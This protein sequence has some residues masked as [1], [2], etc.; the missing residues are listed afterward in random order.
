MIL[1]VGSFSF[2]TTEPVSYKEFFRPQYE[3]LFTDVHLVTDRMTADRRGFGSFCDAWSSVAEAKAAI[4]RPQ[5]Q[6]LRWPRH[7]NRSTTAPPE[8]RRGRSALLS[9]S[10]WVAQ[11]ILKPTLGFFSYS[12]FRRPC[13]FVYSFPRMAKLHC[14][15]SFPERGRLCSETL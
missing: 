2:S 7:L 14:A 13:L 4:S 11:S 12:P 9:Q 8:G 6:K 15:T 3:L 1:Y 5:R 10:R